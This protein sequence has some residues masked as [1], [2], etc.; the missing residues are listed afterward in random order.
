LTHRLIVKIMTTTS[1]G[2]G[3]SDSSIIVPMWRK[4][5]MIRRPELEGK[6]TFT[7]KKIS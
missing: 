3:S 1:D 2:Y 4:V 6:V 7:K 5:K